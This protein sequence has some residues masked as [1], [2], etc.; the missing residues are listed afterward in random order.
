SDDG[1]R[2]S[3]DST[4]ESDCILKFDVAV[5]GNRG[6]AGAG[7]VLHEVDGSLEYSSNST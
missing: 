7:V 1:S 4:Y 5:K 6:S 2:S 3:V